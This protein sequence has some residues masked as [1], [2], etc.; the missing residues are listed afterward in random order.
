MLNWLLPRRY[1]AKYFV[2]GKDKYWRGDNMVDH[3]VKAAVPIF[4]ATFLGCHAVFLLTM[5]P[6]MLLVHVGLRT[7]TSI[8]EANKARY[9][10]TLCTVQAAAVNVISARLL[11]P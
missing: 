5:H 3:T 2:Y 7:L 4:N 8:L 6:T 11:Q 9:G 10:R 1:A